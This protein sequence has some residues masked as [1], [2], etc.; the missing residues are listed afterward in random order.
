MGLLKPVKLFIVSKN[1]QFLGILILT[2]VILS[3][4]VNMGSKI[5]EADKLEAIKLHSIAAAKHKVKL[6][7]AEATNQAIKKIAKSNNPSRVKNAQTIAMVFPEEVRADAIKVANCESSLLEKASNKNRNGSQDWGIF[8]LN[9]GG[10]LQRLGGNA[11]LA[12]DPVWNI[13]AAY[14]LYQDRGWQPWVCAK[15]L[16]L[17]K[18]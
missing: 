10:T 18:R 9:D 4:I 17:G 3:I 8:Q 13:K 1:K 7:H 2:S 16:K 15:A 5:Y 14:I 11:E 6:A 12:R